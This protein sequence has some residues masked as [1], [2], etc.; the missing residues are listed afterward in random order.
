M[1]LLTFF[2]VFFA[3]FLSL[4]LIAV[5]V[6]KVNIFVKISSQSF[7]FIFFTAE[8]GKRAWENLVI[9]NFSRLLVL[10]IYQVFL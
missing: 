7:F 3:C 2:L 5:I 9:N 1:N 4:L 10:I 6:W 8:I